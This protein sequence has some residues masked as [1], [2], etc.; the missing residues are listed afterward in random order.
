MYTFK[1]MAGPHHIWGVCESTNQPALNIYMY[2]TCSKNSNALFSH[3]H[4]DQ[5]GFRFASLPAS[6][7]VCLCT[8]VS[9]R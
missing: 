4:T 6:R 1:G 8:I 2:M 9:K 5:L 3:T 7:A